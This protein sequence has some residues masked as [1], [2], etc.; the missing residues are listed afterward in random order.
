MEAWILADPEKM[1]EFYKKNFRENALPRLPNLEHEG[2][3]SIYSKI[4]AAT[5]DTQKGEYS[6]ANNS[7]ITHA[8]KLLEMIRPDVISVRC[9]RFKTFVKWLNKNVSPSTSPNS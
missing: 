6:D 8:S 3:L 7:K 5:K 2:K 1:K 9:P 4:A